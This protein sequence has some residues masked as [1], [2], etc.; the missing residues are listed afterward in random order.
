M[1]KCTTTTICHVLVKSTITFTVRLCVQHICLC[2]EQSKHNVMQY[3]KVCEEKSSHLWAVYSFVGTP[4][5]VHSC[6]YSSVYSCL[7]VC[8]SACVCLCMRACVRACVLLCL[9]YSSARSNLLSQ[10]R[11]SG[12]KASWDAKQLPHS[13]STAGPDADRTIRVLDHQH[14]S[15]LQP[16]FF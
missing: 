6:V 14:Q 9:P 10:I 2:F 8:L 7:S 3:K 1:K 11:A 15:V 4:M 5:H 16:F 13:T 12:H